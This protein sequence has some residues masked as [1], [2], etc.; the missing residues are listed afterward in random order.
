[1]LRDAGCDGIPDDISEFDLSTELEKRLGQ[2]VFEKYNTD[3]YMLIHYPLKIRP[4]YTM[5]CA[6]DPVSDHPDSIPLYARDHASI[7]FDSL[8]F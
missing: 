5:P 4:F 8:L 1:M 7:S 3:F 6:E 2:I